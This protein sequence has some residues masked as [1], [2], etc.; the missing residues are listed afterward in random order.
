[1]YESLMILP[2]QNQLR[3]LAAHQK[4]ILWIYEVWKMWFRQCFKSIYCRSLYAC[5]G[6]SF[7]LTFCC[8]K[9]TGSV[10]C[11]RLALCRQT[12]T[13]LGQ[14]QFTCDWNLFSCRFSYSQ[15]L[16]PHRRSS[17][18]AAPA[19][20]VSLCPVLVCPPR[21]LSPSVLVTCDWCSP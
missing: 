11:K 3:L 20:G 9:I 8:R 17:P 4:L 10:Y 18:V 14:R 2:E 16:F 1:M 12:T 13:G 7:P 5:L 21:A 15:D 19:G 6:I